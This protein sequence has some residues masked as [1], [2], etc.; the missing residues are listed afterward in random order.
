MGVSIVALIIATIISGG[1]AAAIVAKVQNV[2]GIS[3]GGS[4]IASIKFGIT[5]NSLYED[6]KDYYLSIRHYGKKY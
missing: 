4:A 5:A 2:S 6:V 1:T 3:L